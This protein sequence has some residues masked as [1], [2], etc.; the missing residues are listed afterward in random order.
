MNLRATAA[1]AAILLLPA[2][3]STKK[4]EAPVVAAAPDSDVVTA[5]Q[6]YAHPEA[7]YGKTITVSGFF[8]PTWL[9]ESGNGSCFGD[10]AIKRRA[11]LHYKVSEEQFL[12]A[13]NYHV[14][15]RAHFTETHSIAVAGHGVP[16]EFG[17]DQVL[18][19]LDKIKIYQV[20]RDRKCSEKRG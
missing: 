11:V 17:P 14:I 12:P 16:L 9:V 3:A 13:I 2:C 4:A 1:M 7:Y 20:D 10:P 8:T 15:F 6:L 19:V 5:E 18:G